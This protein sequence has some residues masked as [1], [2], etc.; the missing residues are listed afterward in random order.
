MK[1][2]ITLVIVMTLFLVSCN[3]IS[4]ETPEV[5]MIPENAKKATIAGG[6]FWCIEAA[7]EGMDGIY[8][9]YSGYTG[10]EEVDPTYNE[11]S[12]GK[13]GHFE[14]VQIKYDPTKINYKDILDLFWRQIDPTDNEGQFAD[15]GPQYRTAIFYHDE[16]QQRIAEESIAEIQK[17]FDEPVAT[18]I[19]KATEFY[20]AEEYHQDYS[21]KR[22]VQYQLYKKG[23]GRS[24]YI[25]KTWDDE[26][27]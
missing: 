20:K 17:K 25:K 16:E 19:L 1:W 27:K 23:S 2:I 7:Y 4:N 21:K 11:V 15:R 22:T 26:T 12:S 18:E 13:T 8:D 6:C 14:A 3:E 24:D 10:G 5:K 9:V